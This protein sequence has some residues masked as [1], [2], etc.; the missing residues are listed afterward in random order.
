M[1]PDWY[2]GPKL[3]EW[4]CAKGVLDELHYRSP[5]WRAVNRWKNG[6]AASVYAV[7]RV[8]CEVGMHISEIPDEF[9]T[10]DPRLNSLACRS[11]ERQAA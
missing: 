9:A 1:N 4:I 8:L 5:S 3:A 6:S 7:D 11:R 2:D 10:D